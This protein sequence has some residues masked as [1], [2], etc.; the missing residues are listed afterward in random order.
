MLKANEWV[1]ALITNI[2]TWDWEINSKFSI[3]QKTAFAL[4]ETYKQMKRELEDYKMREKAHRFLR[5]GN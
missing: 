5:E 4:V 1:D 2:D 3:D